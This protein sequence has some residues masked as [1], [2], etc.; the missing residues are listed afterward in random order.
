MLES[1]YS[2]P[3]VAQQMVLKNALLE[4]YHLSTILF[5]F[6]KLNM[7]AYTKIVKKFA[8]NRSLSPEEKE[9][10]MK[11]L[12][13]SNL[14]LNDTIPVL[15]NKLDEV[16]QKIF[17]SDPTYIKLKDIMTPSPEGDYD[18]SYHNFYAVPSSRSRSLIACGFLAGMIGGINILLFVNLI[19][20]WTRKDQDAETFYQN[21]TDDAIALHFIYFNLGLPILLL[22]G[23]VVNLAVFKFFKINYRLI[24]GISHP[25]LPIHFSIL[26]GFYTMVYLLFVTRSLV[27]ANNIP[28]RYQPITLML[29]MLLMTY[30]PTDTLYMH[31]RRWW[32]DSFYRILVTPYYPI[33]FRDFFIADQ[34]MSM[35]YFFAAIGWSFC[36]AITGELSLNSSGSTPATTWYSI[37]LLIFAPVVRAVQCLRRYQMQYGNPSAYLQ[38]V[39]FGKYTFSILTTVV[40]GV[41]ALTG[42]SDATFFSALM[43]RLIS[44]IYSLIWDFVMDFGLGQMRTLS[45]PTAASSSSS[46]KE[47][48]KKDK[49]NVRNNSQES[50]KK[51]ETPTVTNNPMNGSAKEGDDESSSSDEGGEGDDIELQTFAKTSSTDSKDP[52]SH[53]KKEEEKK[54]DHGHGQV[55]I[56]PL[57][58]YYYMI[59]LDCIL[60][61]YWL[62]IFLSVK[63]NS[64]LFFMYGILEVVRRVSWNFFRVEVEHVH[65]CAAKRVI[66]TGSCPL[67]FVTQEL[68]EPPPVLPVL[69]SN[70]RSSLTSNR[71]SQSISNSMSPSNTTR[72]SMNPRISTA[73]AGTSPTKDHHLPIFRVSEAIRGSEM[74]V[75]DDRRSVARTVYS[76]HNFASSTH[77]GTMA[78]LHT[79]I[80]QNDGDESELEELIYRPSRSMNLTPANAFNAING[81]LKEKRN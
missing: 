21:N 19:K 20:T 18:P 57:L 30:W 38:L 71:Q 51:E 14:A 47:K 25:I 40:L 46:K 34:W 36:F 7:L 32:N 64:S 69:S 63:Y 24:F 65:N 41:E 56:Y 76:S 55:I 48:S 4:M 6:Q 79:V 31:S 52:T 27:G 29:I 10:L 45:L 78:T 16:F 5:T 58:W 74:T 61:F 62:P 11:N 66:D 33:Q 67:P 9:Q 8:K 26:I 72:H 42:A 50:S 60:R 75:H 17:P 77:R 53:E 15:L 28:S 12:N 70:N 44:T 81:L 13:Q 2:N 73:T 49:K 35:T 23:M 80:E 37:C 39:N 1:L 59:V 22:N 3:I 43:I 54:D 68:Y